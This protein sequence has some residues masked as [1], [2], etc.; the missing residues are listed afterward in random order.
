MPFG[1]FP[2]APVPG[3]CL[4]WPCARNTT[5]TDCNDSHTW[6]SY[7]IGTEQAVSSLLRYPPLTLQVFDLGMDS[8]PD[9]ITPTDIGRLIVI[10]PLQQRVAIELLRVGTQRLGI[11]SRQGTAS[12]MLHQP[13]SCTSGLLSSSSISTASVVWRGPLPASCSTSSA[14]HSFRCSI[15]C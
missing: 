6:G 5:A 12:R 13:V 15:A 4:L 11:S 7:K 1:E 8:P 14:R 3:G 2:A 9:K 10:E